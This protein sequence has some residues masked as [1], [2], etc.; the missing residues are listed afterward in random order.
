LI[1]ERLQEQLSQQLAG[2]RT[3]CTLQR[4]EARKREGK[5]KAPAAGG[6]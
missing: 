6:V 1:Q 4:G 5:P 2:G 3:L